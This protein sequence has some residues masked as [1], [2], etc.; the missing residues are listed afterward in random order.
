[1]GAERAGHDV[2]ERTRNPIWSREELIVAL[3]FY[4]SHRPRIPNKTAAEIKELSDVVASVA[5]AQG[6]SGDEDFRNVNGVYMKLMN[7]MSLDPTYTTTGRPVSKGWEGQIAK[8]GMSSPET[9]RGVM[10]RPARSSSR[11][12]ACVLGLRR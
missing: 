2:I 4:L 8:S 10:R 5:R 6:L 3:D 11:P 9:R 12:N 1:M 7:F